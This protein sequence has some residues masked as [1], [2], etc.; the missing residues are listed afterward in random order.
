VV[1]PTSTVGRKILMAITGQV[2]LLYVIAHVMGN[3]TIYF[4]RINAYAAGLHALPLLLWSARLFLIIVFAVHVYLGIV[5][6]LENHAA[7]PQGYAVTDYRTASFAGRNMIWTGVFIFAFLVYHLL[8]FTFQITDP[9]ISSIRHPDAFGRPNVF[10]M[11]TRSFQHLGISLAY[12]VSLAALLLHVLHGIQSSFQT[13]GL[14]NDR[15]F[16]VITKGGTL[17]AVLLFLGYIAIPV[18]IVMGIIKG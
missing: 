2:L 14:N 12:L 10:L 7:K 16:P 18:V 13:W 4:D 9:D 6:K 3:S 17:A 1:L 5:L 11:V 15:T 8:Q